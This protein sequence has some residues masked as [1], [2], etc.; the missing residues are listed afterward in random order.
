MTETTALTNLK[1]A[2]FQKKSG[3]DQ[4]SSHFYENT[5]KIYDLSNS[6]QKLVWVFGMIEYETPNDADAK[7]LERR[8]IQVTPEHLWDATKDATI[9]HFFEVHQFELKITRKDLCDRLSIGE[10]MYQPPDK[11]QRTGHLNDDTDYHKQIIDNPQIWEAL[12][13][14][15]NT[16]QLQNILCAVQGMEAFS[17]RA[18][19]PIN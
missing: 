6:L 13:T 1:M 8:P 3:Q 18:P 2:K 17:L 15:A 16:G 12:E 9:Y 4:T 7:S 11:E 5:K 19:N 10:R 14:A